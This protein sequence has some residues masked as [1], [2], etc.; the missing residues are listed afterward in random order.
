MSKKI[1]VA[2]WKMNGTPLFMESFFKEFINLEPEILKQVEAVFCLPF[3]LLSLFRKFCS[4]KMVKLGAQDCGFCNSGAYSG[5]TSP[6]LLKILKSDYVILG[7]SERRS[8]HFES[9]Q[10]INKKFL[11]AQN[12]HL[13]P[14][15]CVGESL[16]D[17]VEKNYISVITAQILNS[18]PKNA[19]NFIIAYEP[20]WAI[21]TG[22]VPTNDE[23]AEIFTVI[24][25]ILKQ[26]AIKTEIRIIY[27]G[28]V[29]KDNCSTLNTV[30]NLSGY[31]VGSASL[32]ANDF[33]AIIKSLL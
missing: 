23:I 25:N 7:H 2:N 31:L 12:N 8:Y 9:D 22:K 4:N 3:P 16:K 27:G 29:S 17:R 21:G 24:K 11:G 20:V 14:I 6:E 26:L 19:H 1:V 28:S 33:L 5:D 30:K 10:M 32:K 15:V 13:I 18:I